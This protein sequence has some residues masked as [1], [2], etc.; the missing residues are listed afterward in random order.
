M[1]GI[2]KKGEIQR[3][4]NEFEMNSKYIQMARKLNVQIRM[5]TIHKRKVRFA[6]FD[7]YNFM[8]AKTIKTKS[9]IKGKDP[10]YKLWVNNM[11]KLKH[12]I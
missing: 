2:Q 12:N 8:F 10:K 11:R 4:F 5:T 9:V 1:F 7:S 3:K 6:D